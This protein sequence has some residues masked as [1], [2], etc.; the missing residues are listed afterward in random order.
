MTTQHNISAK[1][2]PVKTFRDGAISVRIWK[3]EY[4]NRETKEISTFYSIDM[5]R[6]Y[7]SGD[8]WKNTSSINGRDAFKV[9]NLFV[10]ANNWIIQQK[11]SI[12]AQFEIP[13]SGQ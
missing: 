7:K 11:Y 9:S 1:T 3:K 2:A 13:L 12:P 5:K 4:Q 10:R 8:V 6:G